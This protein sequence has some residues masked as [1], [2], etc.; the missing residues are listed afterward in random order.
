M[1]LGG[2]CSAECSLVTVC[3]LLLG[4]TLVSAP[5]LSRSYHHLFPLDPFREVVIEDKRNQLVPSQLSA[6]YCI[7]MSGTF[8]TC[9]SDLS[10]TNI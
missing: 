10:V 4:L 2:M 5:H 7:L 9:V 8:C 1:V 3:C 6:S